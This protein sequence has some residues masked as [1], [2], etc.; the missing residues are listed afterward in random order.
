[1]IHKIFLVP[2]THVDLGYTDLQ[3]NVYMKHS[4]MLQMV[5]DYCRQTD[6][7]PQDAKF[8]WTCET[9][10]TVKNYLSDNKSDP[11]EFRRRVCEKRIEI[12]AMYLNITELYST[13]ELIRSLSYAMQLEKTLGIKIVSA[14]NT[15][16][17]GMSWALPQ[18]LRN[19]KIKYLTMSVDPVRAF[20]PGVLY[21]FYWQ[22]PNGDKVLTWNTESKKYWYNEGYEIGFG[23]DY[24]FLE[25]KLP[26]FLEYIESNGYPFDAYMIKIAR[27][28][29]FPPVSIC[30]NV[31]EW[32]RRHNTPKIEI[33]VNSTFFEYIEKKYRGKIPTYQCSWP[34]CWTDGNASAAY[35]TSL[36][37]N[38]NHS[39][40][41]IE[42]L[43][44]ILAPCEINYSN[45]EINKIW[46]NKF[47]FDEHTWGA[48][49]SVTSPFS[50]KTKA[51][52]AQKSLYIYQAADSAEKILADNLNLLKTKIQNFSGSKVIVF[53]PLSFKTSN[54]VT[55]NIHN[56]SAKDYNFVLSDGNVERVL[57]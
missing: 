47:I 14:I 36:S 41:N 32:N 15:D 43:S 54:I 44:S 1:M 4:E 22:S 21:P 17:P 24:A 48:N 23:K 31:R 29:V 53:N 13:E 25:E 35:E 57:R 10:W 30:D 38:L 50:F 19:L 46:E 33:A 52:W 2:H 18:L 28:N 49:C 56:T 37:R 9:A 45:E 40:K 26:S 3:A 39:L 27:D 42:A 16:I 55:F 11:E 8:K 6:N 51:Q 5:L 7:Y 20:R 34:D 12:T